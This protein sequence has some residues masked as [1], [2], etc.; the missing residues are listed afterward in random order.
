MQKI[1]ISACLLGSPVRYNG[2]GFLPE[3]EIIQSWMNEGLLI[4]YCPEVEGGLAVPRPVAEIS[5]GHGQD[6][7]EGKA[8]VITR[9][10]EDLTDTYLRGA[11]EAVTLVKKNNIRLAVLKS[12]SPACGFGAIYDG[13]FSGVLR[14]GDGVTTTALMREDVKIF[15]EFQLQEANSYFKQF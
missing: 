7:I 15:N 14:S 10:G 9:L 5:G 12:N 13:T 11:K 2:K 1:L 3:S 8:Q 6:V 4:S